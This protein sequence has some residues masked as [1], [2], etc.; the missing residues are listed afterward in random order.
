MTEIAPTPTAA[1][2]AVPYAFMIEAA[3]TLAAPERLMLELAPAGTAPVA[4][5]RC[6]STTPDTIAVALTKLP[7]PRPTVIAT[8]VAVDLYS[9]AS[10]RI[11]SVVPEMSA[12]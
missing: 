8:V 4:A 9:I 11:V 5:A 12:P 10:A 1:P 3:V 7:A 2:S 6:A